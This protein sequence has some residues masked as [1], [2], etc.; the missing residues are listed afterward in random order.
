MPFSEILRHSAL[1]RADVSEE[2]IATFIRV[3]RI[4]GLVPTLAVTN[5]RSSL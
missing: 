2:R 1:L 5:N 4:V 3:T